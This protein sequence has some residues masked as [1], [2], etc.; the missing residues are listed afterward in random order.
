[1]LRDG[2][3]SQNRRLSCFTE[4]VRS[5]KGVDDGFSAPK[6][7][8]C[9]IPNGEICSVDITASASGELDAV[10]VAYSNGRVLSVDAGLAQVSE[11]RPAFSDNDMRQVEHS[12]MIEKGTARKSFLRHRDDILAALDH[13]GAGELR[14]SMLCQVARFPD[15]RRLDLCLLGEHHQNALQTKRTGV[16]TVIHFD[17]PASKSDQAIRAQHEIHA[18]SGRLYSGLEGK[19]VVYDLANIV[20][21]VSAELNES[22]E[23]LHSFARLSTSMVFATTITGANLY[24]T[25]FG[26]LQAVES[27]HT[28]ASSS[29]NTKKRKRNSLDVQVAEPAAV[30]VSTYSELGLC[31]FL[32]KN[33]LTAIQL[34]EEIRKMSRNTK[35]QALL[36]EVTANESGQGLFH[37][38]REDTPSGI[39]KGWTA[40]VD[41][42]IEANDVEA[43]ESLVANDRSLGRQRGSK[44]FQRVSARNEEIFGDAAAYDDLWPLPEPIFSTKLDRQ[45]ILY[46]LSRIFSYAPDQPQIEIRVASRKLL[47]WLALTGNLSRTS[48]E[49]ALGPGDAGAQRESIQPGDVMTAVAEVDDD[50]QL[51]YGLLSLPATW[52]LAEVVQAM[53]LLIRSFDAPAES[54]ETLGPQLALLEGPDINGDDGAPNGD[55]SMVNGDADSHVE[56]ESKAAETELEHVERV[57]MSGLE[58]RSDTL[59]VIMERLHV[60]PARDV[61]TTM[62][63]MMTQKELI[64]LIHMLRIEL[65]DGGWT[66]K[67]VG[68]GADEER[69]E[70]NSDPLLASMVDIIPG[71]AETGPSN[72]AIRA[73]GDLLNCAIDAVGTSGWLVG[74]SGD[75]TGTEELLDSLRAEIS[76]G[77]EGCYEA[78]TLDTFL[79]VLDRFVACRPKPRKDTQ[80]ETVHAVLPMGGRVE[81][82]RASTGKQKQGKKSKHL[83][84][85]EKSKKVG[86]YSLDR[87][88]F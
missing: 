10:I 2:A 57:L 30:V 83:A 16:H 52:E 75:A 13:T 69:Y 68:A 81:S 86:K 88:R 42:L 47:E 43:L 15:Y 1:M 36:S 87:I 37:A 8:E 29:A 55:V 5:R 76:A 85:L 60:F 71:D 84:A 26:S 45:R 82:S 64:F 46:L 56:S 32:S 48:L 78:N 4:N 70:G 73:I 28:A 61:T 66:S 41:E 67:Y 58:V 21:R 20:A 40:R 22:H 31:V 44:K 19:V 23:A 49:D 34:G 11:E 24:E 9:T 27:L 25:T 79:G 65:A 62:R 80:E 12:E 51:M 7:T 18:A 17:L 3:K 38:C 35:R 53:C 63:K 14:G 33:Q 59:R 54:N 77:L 72:Q 74:L 6:K 39:A 50:Y